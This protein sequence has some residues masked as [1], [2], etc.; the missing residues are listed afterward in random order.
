VKQVKIY[1]D[2]ACQGNPGPGGWAALLIYGKQRREISG[3]EPATTNNR[4][5][6]QAAVKALLALREP[7]SIDFYTDSQYVRQGITS[8]IISWKRR[9]WLTKDKS[10]VKNEDLWRALDKAASTHKV[11]WHWVKGHSGHEHNE[12]CDFL[13]VQAI[14]KLRANYTAAQLR[15]ELDKFKQQSTLLLENRSGAGQLAL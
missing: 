3:G 4:M 9:S 1:S 6:L 11:Q 7:C 12:R 15:A 10:P 5:E 2:G 13:A 14:E 8:W